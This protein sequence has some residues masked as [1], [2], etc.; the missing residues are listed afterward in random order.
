MKEEQK[1]IQDFDRRLETEDTTTNPDIKGRK[2]LIWI[3]K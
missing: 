2:I 3:L 1:W